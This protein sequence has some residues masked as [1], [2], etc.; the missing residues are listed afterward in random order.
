MTATLKIFSGIP[1]KDSRDSLFSAL[2]VIEDEQTL[3][4]FKRGLSKVR[5]LYETIAP[6]PDLFDF[7]DPYTWLI[8]VNEAYNKFRDRKLSDL[9][10]YE[11]KT[12]ELIKE[13]L[14][15][16]TLDKILPTFEINRDYLKSLEREKLSKE[17]RIMEMKAALESHIKINLERNPIFESLSHR[18]ERIVKVKNESQLESELR[19]LVQEVAAVE[20]QAK[21]LNITD[22]EFALIN[23]VKKYLPKAEDSELI[24]FVRELLKDV[25][26]G[27][28]LFKDWQR[29]TSVTKEVQQVIFDKC[30]E[31]YAGT[32][33]VEKITAL[34]QEMEQFV[35]KY[36]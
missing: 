21:K 6:D 20:E 33:E 5:R 10:E 8:E 19:Q 22:E 4:Q 25:K 31:K 12:R 24:P 35:E 16:E 27:G 1:R 3:K 30:F 13:K 34:S 7:D 36:N 15:I 2:K 32:L 28:R 18:L 9:S 23:A 17:Q 14:V 29:K 11:E 26:A